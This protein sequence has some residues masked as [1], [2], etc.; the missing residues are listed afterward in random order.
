[1]VFAEEDLDN[2]GI[3][4]EGQGHLDTKETE[5]YNKNIHSDEAKEHLTESP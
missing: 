3:K 4:V 2:K 1:M 5:G